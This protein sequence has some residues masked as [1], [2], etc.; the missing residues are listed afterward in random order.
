[1]PPSL[2]SANLKTYH[3][4]VETWNRAHAIGCAVTV[5]QYDGELI[6]TRTRSLAHLLTL[7][8]GPA[9]IFV[10]GCPEPYALSRVRARGEVKPGV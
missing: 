6:S 10:D 8:H 1:M 3:Q 9:V 5:E 4:A 7:S 2:R